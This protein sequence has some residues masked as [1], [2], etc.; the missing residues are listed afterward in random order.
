[1]ITGK[2]IYEHRFTVPEA[3]EALAELP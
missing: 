1:V 2:A 3:L